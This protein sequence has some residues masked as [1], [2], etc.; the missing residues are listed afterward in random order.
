VDG[1]VDYYNTPRPLNLIKEVKYL[2]FIIYSGFI[3]GN[4]S[5]VYIGNKVGHF[6]DGESILILED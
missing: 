2:V 5:K 6:I 4:N 1:S 3:I